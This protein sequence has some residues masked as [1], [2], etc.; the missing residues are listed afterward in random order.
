MTTTP[1]R[2]WL[3]FSL[4]TLFVVV[5]VAALCLGASF[6]RSRPYT[7]AEIEAAI[8][9][10]AIETPDGFDS[11]GSVFLVVPI[12]TS[13]PRGKVF[14]ALGIK[15]SRI[16][17]FYYYEAGHDVTMRW[18]V[19]PSYEIQCISATN[20]QENDGFDYVDSRRKVYGV[21]FRRA[22]AFFNPTK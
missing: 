11:Q 20:D 17:N 3:R 22:Q 2:R 19:S 10:H 21:Q 1:K 18:R 12:G 4:R 5:T 16:G 15:D 6:Y 8:A 14:D 7:D 9:N 13:M